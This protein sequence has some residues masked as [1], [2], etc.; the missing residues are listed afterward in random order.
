MLSDDN[1]LSIVRPNFGH[2]GGF[3]FSCTTW[4]SGYLAQVTFSADAE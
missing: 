4:R 2:P 3:G 1:E